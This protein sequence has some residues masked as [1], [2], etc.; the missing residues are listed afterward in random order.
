MFNSQIK[1]MHKLQNKEL[2]RVIIITLALDIV[3]GAI[4]AVFA[5]IMLGTVIPEILNGLHTEVGNT[6]L[7]ITLFS[8]TIDP[9]WFQRVFSWKNC[10]AILFGLRFIISYLVGSYGRSISSKN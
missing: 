10:F 6:G 3:G 7:T 9:E 4:A 8:I 5:H 2:A 1:E